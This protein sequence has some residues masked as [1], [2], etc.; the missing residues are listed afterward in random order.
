MTAECLQ[1][2]VV[3]RPLDFD[4]AVGVFNDLDHLVARAVNV[5]HHAT[6]EAAQLV[7]ILEGT[8]VDRGGPGGGGDELPIG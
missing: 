6:V 7:D 5:D 1:C 3:E 4:I 8:D 2:E